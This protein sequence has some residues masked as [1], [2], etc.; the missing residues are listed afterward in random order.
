MCT[1]A[2]DDNIIIPPYIL[3]ITPL[4]ILVSMALIGTNAVLLLTTRDA[5]ALRS[6][7]VTVRGGIDACAIVIG[8]GQ[9][10]E[11]PQLNR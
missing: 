10:V 9:F 11:V 3:I 7:S 4:Y 6:L 2:R 1:L 5:N 8:L